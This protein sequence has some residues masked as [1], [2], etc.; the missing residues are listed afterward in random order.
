MSLVSFQLRGF[1]TKFNYN[2]IIACKLE[3]ILTPGL[4]MVILGV[5][6]KLN[7]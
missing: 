7:S 1:F 3:N 5:P 6:I 2:V 4:A